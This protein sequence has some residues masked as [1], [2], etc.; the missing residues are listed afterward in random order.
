MVTSTVGMGKWP[1]PTYLHLNRKKACNCESPGTGEG[2][3]VIR[4]AWRW[5]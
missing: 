2:R 3:Q 5:V 4:V 1:K